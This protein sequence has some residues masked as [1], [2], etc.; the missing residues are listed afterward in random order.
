MCYDSCTCTQYCYRPIYYGFT[1]ARIDL[2]DAAGNVVRSQQETFPGDAANV[3]STV[4]IPATDNVIRVRITGL[5]STGTEYIAIAEVDLA[6]TPMPE[7][8]PEPDEPIG[9]NILTTLSAPSPVTIQILDP[10]GNV[11]RTLVNNESRAGGNYADYWD[12]RDERGVIVNDDVYYAVMHY[13]AD[14]NPQTLDLTTTTGGQ[15]SDFP[16]GTGCNTRKNFDGNVRPFE[17]KQMAMEFTL[18][19]AQ[20]VTAFIGPLWSGADQTRVRTIAN[21]QVYPT[22]KHIIY[23]DGLDDAGNVAQAPPGDDLITGFW[24]YALPA[25]AMVMTG[26]R[27]EISAIAATP[28]YFSPFSEEC[29]ADGY[30]AGMTLTY[31]LS[32]PVQSVELRV[33]SIATSALLRRQTFGSVPAGEN[34]VFWDG[35]NNQG[36]YVDIGDY[37]LGLV[38]TDAEGN[39]SMLRYT[40]VRID[41]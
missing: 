8:E 4:T 35:K 27:P 25:N 6:R 28:N 40:L 22:G 23:W 14:G 38:A 41:Y 34:A 13:I 18:C 24:R 1:A 32:E 11:A 15:R 17:D 26:G 19:S 3:V 9:S 31:A 30:G 20:E 36:E 10:A 16:F 12:T 37:Q 7:P 21:R 39:A 33:Y 5:S 29:R 2:Y